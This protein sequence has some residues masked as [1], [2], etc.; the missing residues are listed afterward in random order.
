M[1]SQKSTEDVEIRKNEKDSNSGLKA[2]G[3]VFALT[4]S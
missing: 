3:L 1:E 4:T 2:S